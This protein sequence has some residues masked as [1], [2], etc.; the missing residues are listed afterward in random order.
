MSTAEHPEI[1]RLK[2]DPTYQTDA[3]Y[4]QQVDSL[5]VTIVQVQKALAAEGIDGA[6]AERIVSRVLYSD[7]NGERVRA[8]AP[9][10]Q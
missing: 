1:S 7:P 9:R 4:H 6:W 3:A 8:T 10:E 2:A 5:A